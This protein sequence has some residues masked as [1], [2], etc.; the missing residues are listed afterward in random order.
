MGDDFLFS[1]AEISPKSCVKGLLLLF[2][3]NFFSCLS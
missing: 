1:L 3:N 2:N